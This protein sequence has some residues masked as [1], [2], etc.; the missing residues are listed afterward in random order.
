MLGGCLRKFTCFRFSRFTSQIRSRGEV[1]AE[2]REAGEGGGGCVE[3]GDLLVA[4]GDG[5]AA[6]VGAV[7]AAAGGGDGVGG[8]DVAAAAGDAL[9][10]GELGIAI[11]AGDEDVVLVEGGAVDGGFVDVADGEFGAAAAR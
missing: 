1:D 2:A 5:V 10:A 8:A 4:E 9:E 11:G 6:V 7:P 3:G